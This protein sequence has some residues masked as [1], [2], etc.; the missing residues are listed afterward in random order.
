MQL[1][2]QLQSQAAK[3]D[4]AQAAIAQELK[5]QKQERGETL[6]R[7]TLELALAELTHGRRDHT[8]KQSNADSPAHSLVSSRMYVCHQTYMLRRLFWHVSMLLLVCSC[9][10]LPV[11]GLEAV[12]R[13]SGT[14][15]HDLSWVPNLCPGHP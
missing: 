15:A 3:L 12:Q 10:L 9:T 5:A 6:R 7:A 2:Q 1:L 8:V 14:V 13:A 4:S 11:A